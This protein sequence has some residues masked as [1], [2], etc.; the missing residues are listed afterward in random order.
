MNPDH[1]ISIIAN[2]EDKKFNLIQYSET[3]FRKRAC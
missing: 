1:K 3:K 2:Q